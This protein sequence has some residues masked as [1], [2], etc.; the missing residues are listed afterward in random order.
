L[1]EA[2]EGMSNSLRCHEHGPSTSH[3]APIDARGLYACLCLML[4]GMLLP[5]VVEWL[6]SIAP[7]APQGGSHSHSS[8]CDVAAGDTASVTAATK[9]PKGS[10][11]SLTLVTVLLSVHSLFE[12]AALGLESSSEPLGA[13]LLP[14]ALH[15]ACDGLI[16][17]VSIAKSAAASSQSSTWIWP[18]FGPALRPQVIGWVLVTPAAL[19]VLGAAQAVWSSGKLLGGASAKAEA[20]AQCISTGSFVFIALCEIAATELL[21]TSAHPSEVVKRF[22]ALILGVMV[23]LGTKGH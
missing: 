18:W 23:V 11:S 15:K 4:A 5:I 21:H 17:G 1:M 14:M 2:V 22:A 12:G 6:L 7:G 20:A 16:L 13:V 9:Q 8:M 3:G 19:V 10:A